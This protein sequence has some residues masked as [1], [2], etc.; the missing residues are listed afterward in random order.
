V[1]H[2]NESSYSNDQLLSVIKKLMIIILILICSIAILPFI[3]YYSIQPK[4]PEPVIVPYIEEDTRVEDETQYWMPA[5]LDSIEDPAQ[6]SLAEYGKE[7]IIHTSKYLGPKGSVKQISNGLNC[8]NC[9]LKAGTAVFGNN[10]GSVNS[11]YPKFRARS[12]SIENIYKRIIDCIE[13]SLNGTALDTNAHEMRAIATYINYISSNVPK[14]KKAE[15]SGLKDMALL[16]RAA[17]P[18][19]GKLV[20]ETKCASCHQANG[21]G[22]YTADKKEYTYPALWGPN[23]YN[24]AAGLY[25]ISNFA[26]FVKY[27]MPQ[28]TTHEDPQLTDEEA[29]DVAAFVNSQSRPHKEV[30]KDW[31]NRSKKPMD[32]PFGPYTDSFSEKQHKFGPFQAIISFQKNAAAT[33]KIK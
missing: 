21:G 3:F 4:K 17:D 14:G 7:L 16:D 1:I 31:P 19:K 8:Q 2:K 33:E 32:H 9:H 18:E 12:G 25:R 24:D 20:Y 28:G 27:N 15:G 26:K 22:T 13:R 29:W 23:S 5:A 6:K 10:Y 30:P 11:M